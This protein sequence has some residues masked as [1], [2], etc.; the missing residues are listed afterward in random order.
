MADDA[1]ADAIDADPDLGPD[2]PD[3]AEKTHPYGEDWIEVRERVWQRDGH[4]CQRCGADDRTLQAHHVVPRRAGG[5][6]HPSNLV[7][8]CRPCHG[9]MHPGNGSF[10]DVR[11]EASLFPRPDAPG[12]V[13]RMKTP[14]DR[15]CDRCGSERADPADLVAWHRTRDPTGIDGTVTETFVLCNPCG[16]LVF[17]RH[18]ACRPEQLESTTRPSVHELTARSGEVSVRPSLFAE[19]PVA[20]RRAPRTRRERVIDDTPLRFVANSRVA[21]WTT[22]VVFGYLLLFFALGAM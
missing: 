11:D 4:T 6:D 7:T 19:E 15:V 12:P 16:G 2:A 18:S 13:A 10:D 21:R 1:T 8:L 22:V 5:P 14:D 3:G 20:I 17:E 9:V